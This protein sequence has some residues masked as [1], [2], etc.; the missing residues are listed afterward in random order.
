[1]RLPWKKKREEQPPAQQEEAAPQEAQEQ[2]DQSI[3]AK[4]TSLSIHMEK[5]QAETQANKEVQEANEERFAR[6]HEQ[7][8]EIRHLIQNSEVGR[9]KSEELVSNAIT[10]VENTRPQQ[11]MA[12]VQKVDIKLEALKSKLEAQQL[13][14]SKVDEDIKVMRKQY[15]AYKDIKIVQRLSDE[16]KRRQQKLQSMSAD[17][18][19][20]ATKV[21]AVFNNL[22]TAMKESKDVTKSVKDIKETVDK[23][24]LLLTQQQAAT[25]NKA[26]HHDLAT[27]EEDTKTITDQLLEH[28][29]ADLDYFK[30]KFQAELDITVKKE[31]SS[32]V[33]QLVTE[34]LK[35]LHTRLK[36]LEEQR[37]QPTSTQ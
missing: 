21:D 30:S 29:M 19:R 3:K 10:L 31:E 27:L 32:V 34:D 28:V 14:N 9:K 1:M 24:Q 26:D 7:L 35:D 11:L 13:I 5:M 23:A 16:A 8:G 20:K 17:L 2:E 4:L 37:Q 25:K 15:K 6:I 22:E 33:R 18:G 36:T 12:A